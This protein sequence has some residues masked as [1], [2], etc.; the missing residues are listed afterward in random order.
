MNMATTA[1]DRVFVDTNVLI[2][3]T[4][5][6]APLHDQ[7]VRALVRLRERRVELWISNQV[8][9]EYIA[10]LTRPQQYSHAIPFGAVLDQVRRLRTLFK[11]AEDTSLGLDHLL[12]LLADVPTGGKQVHDANVVATM[13]AFGIN[14][15]LTHNIEDVRRFANKIAILPLEESA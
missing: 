4:I 15:I 3:A 7:A 8:I 12:R 9:R 6:S 14:C 1:A 5:A 11:V 13:L 10:N 2:R